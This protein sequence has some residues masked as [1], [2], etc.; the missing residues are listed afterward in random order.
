MPC[1][2]SDEEKA[3]LRG[4][5]GIRKANASESLMKCRKPMGAALLE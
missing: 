3:P 1:V 2:V 4:Q 5:V